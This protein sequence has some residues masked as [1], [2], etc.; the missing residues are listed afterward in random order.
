MLEILL[1]A[2]KHDRVRFIPDITAH[3]MIFQ[4]HIGSAERVSKKT[5]A[6]GGCTFSFI[7]AGR[8]ESPLC[9]PIP[10]L[11]GHRNSRQA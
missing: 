5:C 8:H 7:V 1:T 6:S 2:R 3:D 10:L 9:Y 11:A 4:Q